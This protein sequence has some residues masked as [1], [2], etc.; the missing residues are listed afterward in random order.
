VP[1]GLLA[2]PDAETK[3]AAALPAG[4]KELPAALGQIPGVFEIPGAQPQ[5]EENAANLTMEQVMR[6]Y[7]QGRYDALLKSLEPMAYVAKQHD[8]EQLLGI[9]Y[10][11]GQGV[12]VDPAK[13]F[14]LL[15]RAAEAN[16]PLA[17]HYLA[18]MYFT[19]QGLEE[20]DLIK[21]LMWLHIA[22][23]H[24]PEG[25]EKERAIQDRDGIYV[26]MSRMEK[27]RALQLARDWLDKQGEAHLLDM[28]E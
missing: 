17:Q 8:A 2:P 12:P 19:G 1:E 13:A 4:V 9:M 27:S 7:R 25:P 24:Y 26:R 23:L 3:T 18:V 10:M 21:A 22:I 11:N 28:Q 15:Q 20:P 5:Q 6:E 16:R 14:D